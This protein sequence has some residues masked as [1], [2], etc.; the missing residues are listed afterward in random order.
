[1]TF[2][3]ELKDALGTNNK[4]LAV[5]IPEKMYEILDKT[6]RES[7]TT[8]PDLIR[9]A[10]ILNPIVTISLVKFLQDKLRFNTDWV[11]SQKENG[12]IEFDF[13]KLS[14]ECNFTEEIIKTI[15]KYNSQLLE[16]IIML[17]TE[18]QNEK[19]EELQRLFDKR[20]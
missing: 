4:L 1:M 12:K 8:L 5:K 7:H 13:K 20:D 2:N 16:G 6:A 19:F 17:E 9:D 18:K 3:A 14:D 15:R 10:L 11:S